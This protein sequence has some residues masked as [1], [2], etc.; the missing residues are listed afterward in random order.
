M[1]GWT[2]ERLA[3]MEELW[4]AGMSAEQIA[5][6][7]G[8]GLT[9]SAVAGKVWRRGLTRAAG[10]EAKPIRRPSKPREKVAVK[11]HGAGH[12][13]A[14]EVVATQPLPEPTKVEAGL[15]ARPW[16]SRLKGECTWPID[17][18]AGALLACCDPADGL[19]CRPHAQVA[20]RP[21]KTTANQL[22]RSLR[23]Y[24]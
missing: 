19:Y 24:A 13:V 12:V 10:A 9:R 22:V 2:D 8:G 3:R 16:D 15:N 1:S 18:P 5:C 11:K 20:Y 14:Y 17:G 21:A 7:L 6:D 23:R 4:L